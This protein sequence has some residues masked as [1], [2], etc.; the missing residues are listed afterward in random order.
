VLHSNGLIVLGRQKG[1]PQHNVADVAARNL[2]SLRQE[3]QIDVV[4]PG[5]RRWKVDLPNEKAGLVP[6]SEWYDDRYGEGGWSRGVALN[7]SVGQGEV[8]TTPLQLVRFTSAM[9]NGGI[10]W[11]PF[12][13]KEIVDRSGRQLY[14]GKSKGKRIPISKR[15]LR[16]VRECMRDAVNDPRGTGVFARSQLVQ[17]AGKTGTVENPSGEDHALFCCFAPFEE[18]LIALSM[19]IERSGH[20]GIVAA[21][22][23]KRIIE[24]YLCRK[25]DP[26]EL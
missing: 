18:P 6:T 24:R 4:P 26:E 22:V 8:L 3:F 14:A 10:L 16:I 1:R 17:I 23:A 7:L 12:V 11:R 20:G 2:E 13:V 25:D 19:I 5:C 15:T 21:P 9:A